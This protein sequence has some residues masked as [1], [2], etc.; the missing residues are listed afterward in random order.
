MGERGR[1]RAALTILGVTGA[2]MVLS[3]L[4]HHIKVPD[5]AWPIASMAAVY[6]FATGRNDHHGDGEDEGP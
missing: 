2:L 3:S 1:L 4:D 5:G 6:L